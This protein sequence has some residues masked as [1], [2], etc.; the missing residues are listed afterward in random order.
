MGSA[1]RPLCV[2]TFMCKLENTVIPKV[3][4]KL[5]TWTRYV[6]DT[7]AFIRRDGIKKVE[8]MLNAFKSKIQFTHKEEKENTISFLDLQIK[9]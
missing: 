6:D 3:K 7:F 1:L 8:E 5:N 9:D 4:D 2:N